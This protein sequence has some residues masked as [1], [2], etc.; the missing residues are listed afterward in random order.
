MPGAQLLEKVDDDNY[1]VAIKVKTGAGVDDLP[2]RRV[3]IVEKDPEAHRAV[4][5]R[6]EGTR[7]P[8]AGLGERER[9]TMSLERRRADRRRAR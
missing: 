7:G 6:R 5:E 8:R 2:R 1:K 4:P 3:E 9:S